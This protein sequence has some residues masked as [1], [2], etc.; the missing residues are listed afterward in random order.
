MFLS[1]GVFWQ[2]LRTLS[3]LMN[4]NYKLLI[5]I[6]CRLRKAIYFVV[7]TGEKSVRLRLRRQE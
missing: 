5:L 1:K 4:K 7:L 6:L 2:F 3:F